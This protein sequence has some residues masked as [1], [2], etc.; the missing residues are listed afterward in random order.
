VNVVVLDEPTNHLD[1]SAIEQLQA[2]LVEFAGTLLIVTHDRALMAA[3]APTVTW[4]F[5]RTGDSAA[6]RVNSSQ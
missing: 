6:V 1:T 3:L 5:T 4:D 2:A